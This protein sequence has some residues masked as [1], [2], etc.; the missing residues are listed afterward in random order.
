MPGRTSIRNVGWYLLWHAA[1]GV[2]W[3]SLAHAQLLGEGYYDVT[4]EMAMGLETNATLLRPFNRTRV[5][6]SAGSRSVQE[7]VRAHFACLKQPWKAETQQF[8]EAGHEFTNMVFTLG[9]GHRQLVL[10]AHYDS[11]VQPEGFIGAIDS[12]ASCAMLLYVSQVL[13]AVRLDFGGHDEKRFTGVK[14][15]FFDGEEAFVQWGPKDSLYGSRH[16]AEKWQEDGT[17]ADVHLLVLLDLLGGPGGDLIPNYYAETRDYYE[18]LWLI[19]ARYNDKYSA[20]T[21][22][23][24]PS[25]RPW[26]FIED[27][28]LPFLQRGVPVLHLIPSRFPTNWHTL[29]DDF[30]HLDQEAVN[31]WTVMI[32]EFTL[33]QLGCFWDWA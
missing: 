11:L 4:L 14:L 3:A 1:V 5:S 22:Y 17:L 27:D 12:A 19:E 25:K 18:D 20:S 2:L 29:D 31:K 21:N 26:V 32:T 9:G 33:L 23:L 7:F 8:A 30:A 15:V 6:G 10:A 16:L 13:D 28:H 24:N